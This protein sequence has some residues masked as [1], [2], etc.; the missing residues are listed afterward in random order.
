M[1]DF[2]VEQINSAANRVRE[3]QKRSAFARERQSS[4]RNSPPEGEKSAEAPKIGRETA[5][6]AENNPLSKILGLF[7]FKNF[8][9]DEESRLILG[10]ILLLGSSKTDELLV[11]ALIYIML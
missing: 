6:Q 8:S 10:I 1:E 4:S 9:F 3:M 7:D 2:T 5:G 11:F